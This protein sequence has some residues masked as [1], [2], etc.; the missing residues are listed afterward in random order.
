M[1]SLET[2][3][4]SYQRLRP[5]TEDD[6]DG[7]HAA[8]LLIIGGRAKKRLVTNQDRMAETF[9]VAARYELDGYADPAV[10]DYIGETIRNR[11]AQREGLNGNE[12]LR[13]L[14]KFPKAGEVPDAYFT[15]VYW[16][17][18]QALYGKGSARQNDMARRAFGMAS[19]EYKNLTIVGDFR[20]EFEAPMWE[21]VSELVGSDATP[22]F[23]NMV[24]LRVL[25]F[26]RDMSQDDYMDPRNVRAMHIGMKRNLGTLDDGT[27]VKARTAAIIN[28]VDTPGFD[29]IDIETIHEAFVSKAD[30][31]NVPEFQRVVRYLM[32]E[33]LEPGVALAR[34]ETV[35]GFNEEVAETIE[36]R[37]KVRFEHDEKR[38]FKP[39]AASD[40]Q[41]A[42]VWARDTLR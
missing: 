6:F 13:R 22:H 1:S 23:D 21:E 26:E 20:R 14:N 29:R 40:V 10:L 35:Y 36:S 3:P 34:N 9:T 4:N 12:Y 7:S 15:E 38:R 11:M 32:E 39:H 24:D 28:A 25:S 42:P 17:C 31:A 19:V 37:R 5:Y 2:S 18:H 33:Q 30:M 16:A 8:P 41:A 27:L